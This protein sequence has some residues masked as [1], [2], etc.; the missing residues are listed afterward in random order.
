MVSGF[1]IVI[2]SPSGGG[3][4]TLAG[5]AMEADSRLSRVV[6]CTT[7]QPRGVEK[8]GRD[9]H[10]LSEKQ[11]LSGIRRGAFAEWARVH[12]HYYGVPKSGLRR[13]MR[14]GKYPLLVIDVQGGQSIRKAFPEAVLI[15]LVPPSL[16]VLRQ[17]LAKR[18]GGTD[19]VSLRLE[20]AKTEMAQ[21]V[22]YDYAVVNDKLDKAAG[23]IAAIIEAERLR[24]SRGGVNLRRF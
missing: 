22:H 12:T 16:K 24:V 1:P 13:E 19:N 10:F 18:I 20:T 15:F 11:F 2:S 4:T 7:R 3:K 6:T 14:L 17:R 9:Y 21:A 5:M 8:N 23:Q